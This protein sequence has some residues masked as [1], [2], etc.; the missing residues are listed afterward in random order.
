MRGKKNGG[1]LEARQAKRS[2]LRKKKVAKSIGFARFH[3][4]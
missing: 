3:D 1:F 4:L 2:G